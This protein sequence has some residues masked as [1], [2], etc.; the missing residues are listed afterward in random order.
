MTTL[1]NYFLPIFKT[2]RGELEAIVHLSS[3]SFCASMNV[4]VAVMIVFPI[5]TQL[6]RATAA[7]DAANNENRVIAY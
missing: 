7:L 4:C 6:L 1:N 3:P 5:S 2:L